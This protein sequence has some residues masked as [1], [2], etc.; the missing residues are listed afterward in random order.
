M[1]RLRTA[2]VLFLCTAFSLA[3]G[4]SVVERS[5]E[6]LFTRADRVIYGTV[7]EVR[8]IA[9]E[10][11]N[12]EPSTLVRIDVERHLA[13]EPAE[14]G[15]LP[16]TVDLIFQ[17]GEGA[18]GLTFIDDL[19]VPIV[20]DRILVAYYEDEDLA[21]PVVGMWQG[22]WWL[23]ESG[24]E[25]L[26]RQVLGVTANV[27]SQT[28]EDRDVGRV[29]NALEDALEGAGTTTLDDA[30]LTQP[31]ATDVLPTVPSPSDDTPVQAEEAGAIPATD[32][33]PTE[34]SPTDAEANAEASS[35]T[36]ANVNEQVVSPTS[37][38]TT[39][40]LSEEP[41]PEERAATEEA[42][43]FTLEIAVS[44]DAALR[45]AI[46]AALE[47]W[48]ELGVSLDV[49]FDEG[50]ADRIR[51]GD[52]ALLGPD[53]LAL[54]RRVAGV[55]GIEIL[56]APGAEGRRTDVLA[57]ELGRLAGLATG[58]RGFRAGVFPPSDTLAPSTEDAAQLLSALTNVPED[59]NGDGV[60]DFYDFVLLGQTYGRVGTR[61]LGDLDGSG[62]VDDADVAL[63]QERYTFQP[64]SRDAP[65]GRT[66]ASP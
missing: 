45:D 12:P 4:N 44:E 3:W 28:G 42:E 19:P 23:R 60:V 29:L 47:L 53:V 52:R 58:N 50:A 9:G 56:L 31:E 7:S 64:A 59:L 2:V 24:L 32:A 6:E 26:R 15:S 63:L 36:D 62:E 51:I 55:D 54:S 39:D 27:I 16:E 33:E 30:L 38:S 20:G 35:P 46:S 13:G 18:A 57:Y 43:R 22:L 17:A 41:A 14:D 10:G 8:N 37:D 34:T 61:V 1:S 25:N 21:S 48:S 40:G 65:E 66:P 49:S 11:E 5:I